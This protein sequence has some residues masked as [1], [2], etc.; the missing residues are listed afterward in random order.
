MSL[1]HLLAGLMVCLTTHTLLAT[2]EVIT[3]VIED[4]TGKPIEFANVSMLTSADSILI[5]GMVTDMEGN[6]TIKAA[7]ISSF[8]RI[9]ALGYEEKNIQ[10][11]HGDLGTIILKPAS[12]ELGE[13]IV[14]GSR[15]VA[16]LKNNGIQ[17]EISGT[18][19]ANSG[20]AL[21]VLGKMPFVTKNGST[22]EVLGKGTPIIFI[23]GRQV[24]DQS[25]LNQ[26]SSENIKNIEVVTSPG[27]RYD[28]SVNAVIRIT[29]V[30]TVG[31]G[32]SC[33]DR[34]RIGYKHYV[35]LFE[36]INLNYR[37]NGFDLF[38]MLN[39]ENYSE[40][41]QIENNSTLYL[42]SGTIS[43][44]SYSRNS[45]KYPV[46]EGKI[47][48]NYSSGNQCAGLYYNYAYRPATGNSSSFTSR[49]LNSVLE[50]ELTYC[51]KSR[52]H[53]RQHLLSGYYTSSFG[54]WM[55]TANLD[56]LWQINNHSTIE[57][58]ISAFNPERIFTTDNDVTNRLLAGNISA[59]LQVCNGSLQLGYEISD[60]HRNDL[61]LAD[62][63]FVEENNTT[64]LETTSS[65]FADITQTFGI[66]TVNAGL[67]WEYTASRY[68]LHNE[69]KDDQSRQYHN[70]A[71]SASLSLAIGKVS[72]NIS[73][74]RKT[75]KPA[76]E[77]LRSS[78]RYLD[79]YSYES[80]NPNLKP[81]YRNYLTLAGSWRD[82]V[83]ELGW[84]STTN[85]FMWQTMPYPAYPDATLLRMENMPKYNT[86]E[87]FANYSPCF[88]T[89]W[90]PT[91]M[92]GVMVQ[93]FKLMHN[94]EAMKLN[95]PLGIFRF[96]NAINLPWDIWANIDFS[97]QTSGNG[98]NVYMNSRWSCDLGFYKSFATDT[99][100]IKLQLND[101]F[102]TY[103]QQFTTYD[104]L[105]TTNVNKIYD[106]RD[107]C[108][109]I[110]YNFNAARSRY[111]GRGAANAEKDRF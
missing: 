64:I 13:I 18:Y 41:P 66:A 2:S 32:F 10:D 23:N 93:D 83:I 86:Y 60:V 61:Y 8:L 57:R 31:E 54:K 29:T 68:F 1:N 94:G 81:I 12:F 104:A 34:T 33:N 79:R 16:T 7:T 36:Q 14:K 11:P 30:S 73:Y 76:F 96:N 97:A 101:V 87:V 72:T 52:R 20:T 27:A 74:V 89:I 85:Y 59:S 17:V 100:S 38:T 46:Y 39:Y 3:G 103:R 19:L 5:D 37:K 77:Q 75:T 51:G 108:L 48:F 95:K 71:P 107:L 42:K 49:L 90:R 78:V 47:G 62:A 91:F 50:D 15:P 21:D 110:R 65:L 92:A 35:Y 45:T 109:T 22:L 82:L 105:S 111:K 55:V 67:R 4:E 24:R 28:S 70:L 43:Q 88:F 40:R 44:N 9:S 25:E 98:D 53:N 26:L 106:T 80:G 63:D 84:C 99:W 58:E 6:F 56:A 69:K 102:K